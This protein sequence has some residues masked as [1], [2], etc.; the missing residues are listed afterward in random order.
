MSTTQERPTGVSRREFLG[1]LGAGAVAPAM[2]GLGRTAHA[3][4]FEQRLEQALR[5]RHVIRPD[6]FGRLFPNLPPFAKASPALETALRE[7]GKKGGIMDA[8]DPLEG[9]PRRAVLLITEVGQT[10]PDGTVHPNHSANNRNN[11]AHTA[12]TTFLGQF[13]D[14]DFTFDLTSRLGI[15][16]EPTASPN[17]RTPA[18]DLDSV[19]GGGPDRSPELHQPRGRGQDRD[20]DRRRG[21]D[22][23]RDDR[24]GV[25]PKLKIGSGGKFED[26]PRCRARR[27]SSA[28]R[29][30]TRTSCSA[31]CTPRSSSSTTTCV[32]LLEKR[33]DATS[34]RDYRNARRIVTWHYQWIS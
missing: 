28:T 31:G 2:L 22:R 25:G 30:T 27:R 29:A 34:G 19:Y 6:R 26:L 20:R 24:N 7:L 18:L 21:Q 13:I 5:G 3:E 14:H 23:D 8:K 1:A 33:N 17:T 4:T 11:P 10:D 12:G 32:E 16:V 15:P 9:N